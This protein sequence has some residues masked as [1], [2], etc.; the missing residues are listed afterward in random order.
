ML[1]V[2]STPG[3]G[4]LNIDAETKKILLR[5]RQAAKRP[6]PEHSPVESRE[7]SIR[8]S[9]TPSSSIPDRNSLSY[10]STCERKSRTSLSQ[11][12]YKS[13]SSMSQLDRKSKTPSSETYSEDVVQMIEEKEASLHENTNP[14]EKY[15]FTSEL[16]R[17]DYILKM[18]T[19]VSTY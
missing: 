5:S 17:F 12:D 3:T 8:K 16:W 19:K 10:L 18:L 11:F 9:Q 14:N 1:C 4:K 6:S 15:R 13:R 7:P 2:S